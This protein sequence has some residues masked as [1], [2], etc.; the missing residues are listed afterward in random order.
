MEKVAE[1]V[2]ILSWENEVQGRTVKSKEKFTYFP[3]LGRVLELLEGPYAGSKAFVYY[4]PKRNETEV[5]VVGE[6]KSP[7]MSDEEVK[8]RVLRF[9]ERNF[10]EDTAY[11]KTMK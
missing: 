10:E 9:L 3:P 8:K 4:L 11:L 1:N 7:I 6:W 5:N 2:S